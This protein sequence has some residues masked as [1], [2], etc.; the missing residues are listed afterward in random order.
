MDQIKTLLSNYLSSGSIKATAR[1]LKVSKNTVREYVRRAE[2]YSMDLRALLELDEEALSLIIH[3]PQGD[4]LDKR[5]TVFEQQVDYWLEELLWQEYRVAHP[6]GYGY[7]QFCEHLLC[8]WAS[9]Q[10]GQYGSPTPERAVGVYP[11]YYYRGRQCNPVMG[12]TVT[13]ERLRQRGY[14]S[15]KDYYHKVRQTIVVP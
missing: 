2:A 4:Q 1:Q 14:I 10:T 6:S 7:S 13:E 8:N 11:R 9:P 3:T 12:M 15:F 5:A